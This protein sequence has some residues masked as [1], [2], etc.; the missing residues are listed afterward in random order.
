MDV[1]ALAGGDG[2]LRRA[3]S[4]EGGLEIVPL[5]MYDSAR[6]KI[7]A[8]LRWVFA[9]AYGEGKGNPLLQ[10]V[11]PFEFQYHDIYSFLQGFPK[12]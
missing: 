7:E 3:D 9:K 4:V 2:V 11:T 6:A 5:E 12:P 8:N 10:T 1:G